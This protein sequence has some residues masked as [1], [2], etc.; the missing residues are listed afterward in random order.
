MTYIQFYQY[1]ADVPLHPAIYL[2][3]LVMLLKQLPHIEMFECSGCDG[4]PVPGDLQ[5]L[6][7]LSATSLQTL[8]LPGCGLTGRLPMQWSAWQG[9][10]T[11]DLT[12]NMVTGMLPPAWTA[13]RSLSEMY[14]RNNNL[15]GSLPDSW[16]QGAS[17]PNNLVLDISG[18]KRLTGSIPASWA[19]VALGRIDLRGTGVGG[20]VPDGL[21]NRI[22]HDRPL[23]PCSHGS[24]AAAALAQLKALLEA[25]D[26]SVGA[27]LS[28]WVTL[29]R[30][31]L[32]MCTLKNV[33]STASTCRCTQYMH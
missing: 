33:L 29:G 13:M 22:I 32:A 9:V 18:N 17:M 16:G 12:D 3:P 15:Q 27:G 14:L 20:C 21:E 6:S 24:L 23:R 28:S 26:I 11:I 25:P 31:R 5:L 4:S 1:T 8:K 30:C 19:H 10:Q 2:S 7:G